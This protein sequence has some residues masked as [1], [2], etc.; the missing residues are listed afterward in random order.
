MMIKFREYLF[1]PREIYV[2]TRTGY[3]LYFFVS[4]LLCNIG[5]ILY[6]FKE[7]KT[8]IGT[9]FYFSICTILLYFHG[10][11][12]SIVTLL[13]V[14]ILYQVHVNRKA[15]SL[16]R[17][18]TISFILSGALIL[19]FSAFKK[20]DNDAPLFLSIAGYADYTRNAIM[21]IDSPPPKYPYLGRIAFE[22]EVYSRIPRALMPNKPKNFGSYH[23]AEY[24]F[25]SW[26]EGDTGS[27]S[28]GIGVQYA[29]FG[30]FILFILPLLYG[31]AA[32][33][34]CGIIKLNERQRRVDLFIVMLFFAGIV[35]MP[36]G[37]GYLLPE[38]LV[39][40]YFLQKFATIR[41]RFG[42]AH[43]ENVTSTI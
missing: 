18:L 14:Y 6:L 19:L 24:Y 2:Q 10:T 13:L 43:A 11:K 12:G 39:F 26:F 25:P 32:Y 29:D 40:A 42:N 1:S 36:L 30:P 23:L 28:F 3:G 31:L 21:V 16:S 22:E 34:T 17:A 20:A 7:N 33:I 37:S 38:T 41:F 5:F 4:I 9:I 8:K 35:I 27:P 15:I